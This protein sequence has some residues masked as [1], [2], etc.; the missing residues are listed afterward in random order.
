MPTGLLEEAARRWPHYLSS[1]YAPAT[2]SPY[3]LLFSSSAAR[4]LRRLLR[5]DLLSTP[6]SREVVAI[7]HSL[8]LATVLIT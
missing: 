8:H 1:S 2:F 5:L 7:V 4:P 6:S 3:S